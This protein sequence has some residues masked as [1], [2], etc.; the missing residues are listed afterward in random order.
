MVYKS[1]NARDYRRAKALYEDNEFWTRQWHI[2]NRE[3]EY[4]RIY[5]YVSS[6]TSNDA[7]LE[8]ESLGREH[9]STLKAHLQKHFGGAGADIR[10]RE[11]VYESGMPEKDGKAV[12]Y[13]NINMDKKLR[14]MAAKR[15]NLTVMCP[16]AKRKDYSFAKESTLVKLVLKHLRGTEFHETAKKLLSE[17]KV[18]K[19]AQAMIPVHNS[20]GELQ[21]PDTD[22]TAD[23]RDDWDFRNYDTRW[24][25]SWDSLRSALVADYK[26][27]SFVGGMQGDKSK[28][29]QSQQLPTMMHPGYGQRNDIADNKFKCYG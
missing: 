19:K 7:A 15:R 22:A 12:F 14:E 27:A 6:K 5:D 20:R 21:L 26:E 28:S 11:S 3:G 18:L 29:K 17:I 24:L 8:V 2:E 16:E 10:H 9:A 4:G 23:L 1:I 13:N 25:P